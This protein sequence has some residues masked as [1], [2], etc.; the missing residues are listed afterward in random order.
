MLMDVCSTVWRSE[1]EFSQR[2]GE[3]V[4]LLH[5][6][7]HVSAVGDLLDFRVSQFALYTLHAGTPERHHGVLFELAQLSYEPRV[8]AIKRE[9][10]CAIDRESPSL[11]FCVI[12]LVS[13]KVT[14]TMRVWVGS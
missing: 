1:Q 11:H 5:P 7:R 9:E 3:R 12:A 13:G 10:R 6:N 4:R 2:G 14:R 8:A